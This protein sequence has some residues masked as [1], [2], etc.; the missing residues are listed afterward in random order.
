MAKPNDE[1]TG[2]KPE[3]DLRGD[4]REQPWRI[5]IAAVGGL[6]VAIIVVGLAGFI[7]N[8]DI[9]RAAN[10]A[11]SYDVELEDHGDDL[12]VA[13]LEVRHYQRTLY[14][15]PSGITRSGLAD[16]ESSVAILQ[17]EIDQL[18]E[19]GISDYDVPQPEEL[20][21]MA[22]EYY[23]DFRPAIDE[24]EETGD[25][26]AWDD[27]NFL[28][29]FRIDEMQSAAQE[30]DLLGENLSEQSLER[31]NNEASAATLVLAVVILGLLLVGIGLAYA[32]VRVVN[33]MRRLY[34]EQR[35]ASE[36]LAEAS[37]AKTDFLADVSHELRTPLTVLRGNAEIG[38]Q[39]E[40]D[41][42]QK[43]MLAEI[44]TESD[45]M[46][47]MV[48]DLL[49]LARSDASS[50]PLDRESVS[51]HS[52]LS[53]VADRAGVL[54][55]ERGSELR[56]N[57]SAEGTLDVDRGRLEQAILILV[58]NAAKYAGQEEPVTL[59]T[60]VSGGEL[61][62]EVA[63]RGPGIPEKDLPRIF[64][65]FY[66]VDK[67]RSRKLGGSGLGLP[68]AKT[69]VEAHGG[70]IEA[71]SRPGEGTTMSIVLPTG[72]NASDEPNADTTEKPAPKSG[73]GQSRA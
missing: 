38:M 60:K 49:F 7:V 36:K 55:R 16:F 37:R 35:E 68:I 31:V 34:A 66:R 50:L 6:L 9:A 61:N 8:R 25:Q 65:R 11:L 2:S 13:I 54:A 27:A 3:K 21:A 46:T 5:T 10:Q 41:E 72:G 57:I 53:A 63:D 17:D 52:Y 28:G 19:L 33:E 40:T 4:L 12:R 39:F 58:D 67:T 26:E 18:E 32:A 48:E 43:E 42:T 47:K 1:K 71:R 69:I 59:S 20:R 73:V 64:E 30:I 29:L 70:R 15:S 51:A 44:L 14:F 23:A 22:D 24:Y 62:V 45:K 56:T